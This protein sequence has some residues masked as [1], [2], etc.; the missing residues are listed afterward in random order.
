MRIFLIIPL[1]MLVL[2]M[3]AP[4]SQAQS[5]PDWVKNTAG[6][7]A[8][9]AIS[10][11]EF[12]NAIEFLVK[13]GIIEITSTSSGGSSE[14]V[15]DWVKNTAGWWAT[16]AI[17]ET[18]FVNA[19]T[20]L[21]N[22][23]IIQ[24]E[25]DNKC[26]DNFSKYFNDK[27][28]IIDV[29]NEHESSINEELIPYDVEL[30]FN[31][32]GF[33][34][35]EFSE[36]KLSDIYRII[37]VGGS[38]I[39]SA[40]TIN[41]SSIPG[42]MQKMFDAQKINSKVEV[43]NAG[44]SGGNSHT[45]YELIS[46]KLVNYEPDLI[47]IYDGWNDL[48]ADYPV[49]GIV[50]KW[51]R[52]CF[53]AY[54]NNFDLIITLQPIA[55]FGNKQ[56][57]DQEYINSL[58]GKDHNGFQLIQ[59]KATY[60]WMKK[61]LQS[62]GLDAERELGKGICETHDLRSIFDD[63]KGP[64]YWDQ[65]HVLHSG[66]FIV[67]EKFFELAMEK[68]EPAYIPDGKFTEIISQYNNKSVLSFLLE[69]LGINDESFYS[70][71]NS[72]KPIEEG[73]GKYF[74]L[75]NNFENAE[76]ILVGKDLSQVNLKKIYFSG[77]D[78]TGVNLSGHDLRD[79]DF[80]DVIIRGANLSGANLEGK[81]LSGM[82]LR[83]INFSNA[84]L[85]NVDFTDVIF[86][87]TIQAAGSFCHDENDIFNDIKFFNCQ[88]TVIENES[89]K[90]DFKNADLNG[91][92]FGSTKDENQRVFFAD[93]KNAD[94]TNVNVDSV[95]FFGCDFTNTKLDN[96]TAKQMFILKSD[97]KNTEMNYFDIRQTWIQKTSFNNAQMTNGLFDSITFIDTHFPETDLEGTNFVNLNQ[98]DS[99]YN[100]EN[101][102][103]CTK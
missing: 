17:S 40:D 24:V 62:L 48:V 81:D 4:F 57:T 82:D 55:G 95:Q 101:N 12:V 38:T 39:Q 89:M 30:N 75:K 90:N 14:S 35:E 2:V 19:V 67:A 27:Q 66:N 26:V 36:Q 37:I 88:I 77:N 41:D 32:K 85:R 52:T 79:V 29:C 63:V 76:K 58:T 22:V 51:E 9:D 100:C 59:A 45:E 98:Y 44:V 47:I 99:T 102:E 78:L 18:E 91:A 25:V 71:Q 72:I 86:S 50:D 74:V 49:K 96:L 103:I 83:G 97:F 73:K 94:L 16:D 1:V 64:V 53:E 11:T 61:E 21:V 60:E 15:P 8:T 70:E 93:F 3:G 80:T 7:W 31:S 23:G 28:G 56:L 43:I 46:N 5:V 42:I 6:W 33:R 68:I 69:N 65:G 20:F 13:N 34:G 92:K 54:K 84:N 10:E 87:K